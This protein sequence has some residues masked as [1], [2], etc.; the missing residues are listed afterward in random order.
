VCSSDLIKG[1]KMSNQKI[2]TSDTFE[3]A[4]YLAIGAAILGAELIEENKKKICI[5]SLTGENLTQAQ[6]DYF[7]SKAYVNIWDFRRC[8][9]R[10]NSLV[11]SVKAN[12]K[13]KASYQGGNQ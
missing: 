10:I 12:E 8:L 9:T 1:G 6:Q 7:N 4:F 3:A 2:T 5:F 13:K 11:G